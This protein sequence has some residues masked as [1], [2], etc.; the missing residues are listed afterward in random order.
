MQVAPNAL[1]AIRPIIG[2][3]SGVAVL[4]DNGATGAW[5][6]LGGYFSDVA[7]GFLSRAMKAESDLGA[8]F[9][10]LADVAFH[11]AVG[12]GLT[13][14]AISTGTWGI[15][16]GLGILVV[17][18]R[19]IRRWISAHSVVGRV[20]GGTNRI[21]MFALL[22]VF[23]DAAQRSLLIEVALAVMVITFVYEGFVTLHELRTGERPVR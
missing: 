21:V 1:A 3:A 13:A 15:L 14:A 10:S 8:A 2:I 4:S 6:Y 20:V 19:L 7:D 18:E 9:D 12:L 17:G 11:A 5:L 22:L 23:C 16:V